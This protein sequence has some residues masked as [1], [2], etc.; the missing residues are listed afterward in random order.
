MGGALTF[1]CDRCGALG[2]APAAGRVRCGACG[3]VSGVEPPAVS[4]RRAVS[5]VARP[6]P[7]ARPTPVAGASRA[8]PAPPAAAAPPA[9]VASQQGAAALAEAPPPAEA[10]PPAREARAE[11]ASTPAGLRLPP[12]APPSGPDRFERSEISP[13]EVPPPEGG[14]EDLILD[15][16]EAP[17]A[18]APPAEAAPPPAPAAQP[19]ARNEPGVRAPASPKPGPPEFTV[20]Y[21]IEIGAGRPRRIPRVVAAV[22]LFGAGAALA[23]GV[24]VAARAVL[25]EP[26]APATAPAPL[27]AAPAIDPSMPQDAA[28]EP[29]LGL[30]VVPAEEPAPEAAPAPPAPRRK[31]GRRA[32]AS[33]SISSRPLLPAPRP[34]AGAA[35][36]EGV[37]EDAPPELPTHGL[38]APLPIEVASAVPPPA[39]A[40][41]D[42]PAYPGS[43][44]R[45]PAPADRACVERS[46]RLPRD[47]SGR[48]DGT[49]TVKFP[50]AVDGSVGAVEVL[51]PVPDPRVTQA[52]EAAI[53]SCRFNPGTDPQG[54]PTPLWAVMPL[55]FVTR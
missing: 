1:V 5:G 35:T 12:L 38:S 45:K 6:T 21:P 13:E 26:A 41:E 46:L 4:Q 24:T 16:D 14:Y 54:K 18:P 42:A 20:P 28:P 32:A 50:V 52:V 39:P 29:A 47:L 17:A 25:R 34:V 30:A 10:A 3:R 37:P 40:V 31:E 51:G 27:A 44:F 43:G 23:A 2:R 9:G 8:T 55:R 49:L 15:D 53:R 48:F 11:R 22:V 36:G 19:A 7:P 33:V